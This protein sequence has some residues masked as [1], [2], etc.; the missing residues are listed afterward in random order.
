MIT[1]FQYQQVC[2]ELDD[3]RSMI[4]VLQEEVAELEKDNREYR[5]EKGDWVER[6][7]SEGKK[8]TELEEKLNRANTII[9]NMYSEMEFKGGDV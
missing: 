4:K 6:L 9:R 8:I 2:D 1:Q 7:I 3:T 5:E